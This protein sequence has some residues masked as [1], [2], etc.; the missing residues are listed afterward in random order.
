[1]FVHVTF[2]QAIWV[3]VRASRKILHSAFEVLTK[4]SYINRLLLTFVVGHIDGDPMFARLVAGV[5][6]AD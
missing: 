6:I 1:M 4:T 3:R 2:K 5:G